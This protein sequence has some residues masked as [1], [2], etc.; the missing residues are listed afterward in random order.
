MRE[1]QH[2]DNAPKDGTRIVVTDGITITIAK[3]GRSNGQ[4]GWIECIDMARK[5]ID[6]THWSPIPRR[7]SET[8]A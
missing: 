2:I 5:G 8:A 7:A 3:W 1:W 4:E 6:L